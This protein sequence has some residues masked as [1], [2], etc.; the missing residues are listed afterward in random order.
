ME[1]HKIQ[2]RLSDNENL[3]DIELCAEEFIDFIE[4]FKENFLN[5]KFFILTAN[6][7]SVLAGVLIAEKK[8]KEIDSL[9]KI[10][11]SIQFHLLYVNKKFRNNQIGKKL[12]DSFI[13]IQKK[14]GIASIYIELPQKYK[15]GI[16]FLQ[17]RSF[18]RINKIQNNIILELKLWNDYG[19]IDSQVIEEDFNDMLS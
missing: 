10:I 5:G 7:E 19:I 6:Y 1:S 2:I 12:L 18:Q 4:N 11:P 17:K 15:R 3:L 16:N 14:N 8:V 13:N 9:E